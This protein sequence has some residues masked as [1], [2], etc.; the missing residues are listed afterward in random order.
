MAQAR[1]FTKAGDGAN[2]AR[3]MTSPMSPKRERTAIVALVAVF[4]LLV[5]ALIPAAALAGPRLVPGD[6]ICA[7][8]RVHTVDPAHPAGHKALGGMPCQDCLS[9]AMAAV[10]APSPAV[11]RVA[12]AAAEVEHV[13]SAARPA[14]SAG[15]ATPLR[16]GAAPSLNHRSAAPALRAG[17][18]L[19]S[20][21][22]D[23]RCLPVRGR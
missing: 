1:P 11:F 20:C 19:P 18:R 3:S 15:P 8:G 14:R 9:A 17:A 22:Q 7:A 21:V 4:A 10:A 6:I 12:Y 23:L 5:Q 2:K 16:P 13:A